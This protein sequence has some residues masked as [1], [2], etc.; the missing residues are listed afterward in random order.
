MVNVNGRMF[1]CYSRK[2]LDDVTNIIHSF[3]DHGI[4]TWQD[5]KDL[6]N[7]QTETE[8]RSVLQGSDISGAIMYV[9]PEVG[10]SPMIKTVEAPEIIKRAVA[11]RDFI[12]V[13]V[14]TLDYKS[15]GEMF[16]G[17]IG[18]QNLSTWNILKVDS[19]PLTREDAVKLSK[20]VLI[21]RV[22]AIHR[23]IP[24]GEFFPIQFAVRKP[25]PHTDNFALT[26]DWSHHFK[27]RNVRSENTWENVLLPAIRNVISAVEQGAPQRGIEVSGNPTLS[28]ALAL[29]AEC[30]ATRGINLVWKQFTPGQPLSDWSLRSKHETS[31]IKKQESVFSACITP[32]NV[33]ANDLALL[34]S[35]TNNVEPDFSRFVKLLP[36]LR[37]V[38]HVANF[39]QENVIPRNDLTPRQVQDVAAE[40]IRALRDA[41]NEYRT[42]GAVHVFM[43]APAG[44]ACILGQLLNTFGEV[45]TYE[46]DQDVPERYIRAVVLRP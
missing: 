26:V 45:V 35:I 28:A 32:R 36:L 43:A 23:R 13:I 10:D 1:I 44:L 38:I 16:Q 17:H 31:R 14:G 21:Q 46:H 3:A 39:Q 33:A 8:I 2:R 24:S 27:D 5:V 25:L 41:R 20:R 30:L 37:A 18:A 6:S 11:D 19:D 15:V 34:L 29:G 9:T 7:R 12:L 22:Q 42:G 4:P 40:A